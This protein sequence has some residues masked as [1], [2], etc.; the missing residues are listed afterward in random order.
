MSNTNDFITQYQGFV[1]QVSSLTSKDTQLF[2]ARIKELENAGINF[3]QFDTAITGISGEAGEISDLWKKIKFH[4]KPWDAENKEKM[5]SEIGDLMWYTVKLLQE[6]DISLEDVIDYNVKK[7]SSRY[8]GGKFSIKHS[9]NRTTEY[10]ASE[11]IEPIKTDKLEMTN[12]PTQIVV[13][14]KFISSID[15]QI[16]AGNKAQ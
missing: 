14:T 15:E 5:V 10:Q 12:S 9:E 6:L 13:D 4:S 3:A 1:E 11:Y 2:L 8:P 7:L 16:K